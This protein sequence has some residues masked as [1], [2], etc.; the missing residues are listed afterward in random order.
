M[1]DWPSGFHLV[2]SIVTQTELQLLSSRTNFLR[3]IQLEP[4]RGE[5]HQGVLVILVIDHKPNTWINFEVPHRLTLMVE[6]T[7]DSYA[8]V[9]DHKNTIDNHTDQVQ[10]LGI[11]VDCC[12]QAQPLSSPLPPLLRLLISGTTE[13][14]PICTN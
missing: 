7:F 6:K 11:A 8:K 4:Q 5:I 9:Q 12:G 14:T 2:R 3:A 10:H 1:I 13:T